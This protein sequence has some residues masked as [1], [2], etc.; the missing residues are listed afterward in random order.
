MEY[1]P[2]VSM[3]DPGGARFQVVRCLRLLHII[4][5]FRLLLLGL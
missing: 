5:R 1:A 3:T 4:D 2:T